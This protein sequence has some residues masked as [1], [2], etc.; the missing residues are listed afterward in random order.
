MPFLTA[1]RRENRPSKQHQPPPLPPARSSTPAASLPATPAEGEIRAVHAQREAAH[2]ATPAV[3]GDQAGAAAP[4]TAAVPCA[5]GPHLQ[6]R[7][8]ASAG[9][10]PPQA[11]LGAAASSQRQVAS[12][13]GRGGAA[14]AVSRSGQQVKRFRVH[15]GADCPLPMLGNARHTLCCPPACRLEAGSSP[16]TTGRAAAVAAREEV[17]LLHSLS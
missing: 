6:H 17:A 1:M 2:V 7:Q 8:V 3:T 14:A 9:S 16:L 15:Q 13:G 4:G 5:A 12:A 11:G 10:Q